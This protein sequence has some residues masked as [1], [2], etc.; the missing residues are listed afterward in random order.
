MRLLLLVSLVA[1]LALPFTA[2]AQEWQEVPL[3]DGPSGGNPKLSDIAMDGGVVW[4]ST[5]LDGLLAYDGLTW[6]LHTVA[7]GGLRSN[8]WHNTILV[9]ASGEK[10]TS[11]DGTQTVDRLNDGGTFTD[12]SD[13]TWTYYSQPGELSSP[14]VFSIAEDGNGNKW[15]GIKDETPN[16]PSKLELLIENDPT[17]TSDDEW[18][19]YSHEDFPGFERRDVRAL[20][21]DQQ[22][23]LWIV[24]WQRRGVDVWDYGDYYTHDDDTITHYG[25]ADGLPSDAIHA[26]LVASDGRVWLG[27]NNGLA[28]LDAAGETWTVL[29]DLDVD[30]VTDVAEDA[31]GHVWAATDQGVAMLY[32][33]GE[34]AKLYTTADGLKHD[35][36]QLIAV[37]RTGGTVW[38]VT[39]EMSTGETLLNM[40]E[41]GFGLDSGVFVYPNPWKEGES[42]E[43]IK[44]QGAP[45][46]STVEIFDITGQAV[47][48]LSATREPYVWDSLDANLNEVPSGVYVIRVE[49]PTGELIFTKVAIIR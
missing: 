5:D 32:S 25:Q 29:A 30:E 18:L 20:A 41:T 34:L 47:R 15:F 39:E 12:K 42:T 16:Q 7:D 28:V 23:R 40:L 33:S 24:Y 49:T 35:L 4:L 10:W 45:E 6:V 9:D 11:K 2:R 19:T 17:T 43:S 44:V 14:R 31:Q 1:A 22:E 8:A 38:A 13:D 3:P 46:G 37:G 48:R 36:V 27:G 21:V 26:V